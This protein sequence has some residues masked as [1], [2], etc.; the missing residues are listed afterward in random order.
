MMGGISKSR[1]GIMRASPLTGVVG[2]FCMALGLSGCGLPASGPSGGAITGDATSTVATGPGES[3][4][5]FVLVALSA[6]TALGDTAASAPSLREF[7]SMPTTGGR[8]TLALAPGDIVQLTIFESAAGGLFVPAD[9]SGRSGNFVTLPQQTVDPGGSIQVPYAGKVHVA[10]LSTSQV[11]SLIE[12]RL[13]NRAIE[14]QVV[15][16][17][18]NQ[19][20]SDVAVIGDVPSANKFALNPAGERVTDVISR[21][22]G[23]KSPGYSTYVTLQ[24]GNRSAKV[25]FEDLLHSPRENVFVRAGDTVY[26]SSEPRYYT[27]LG[28]TAENRRVEFPSAHVTLAEA[29]GTSGGLAETRASPSRVYLYRR[30]PRSLLQRM[31]ADLSAFDPQEKEIPTVYNAD[32]REGGAFFATQKFAMQDNDVLYVADAESVPVVKALSVV[33]AATSPASAA[34]S[35]AYNVRRL[36][37]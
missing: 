35:A 37:Q 6:R 26:V 1:V 15:V 13:K 12:D 36:S 31:G 10:G 7:G 11:Q 30:E 21:A 17:V 34:A 32:L 23:L 25:A 19:R 16:S 9:A 33:S 8:P 5:K 24:R 20:G 18:V 2:A 14:P 22:G 4:T 27:V 28:A 29:L 3:N